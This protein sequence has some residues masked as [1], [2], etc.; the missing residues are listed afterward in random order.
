MNC[1]NLS[2]FYKKYSEYTTGMS[3]LWTVTSGNRD[4]TNYIIKLL[5]PLFGKE[6][7]LPAG[8]G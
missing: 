7:C 1:E 8:R 2:L 5:I 4:E 3:R 6:A